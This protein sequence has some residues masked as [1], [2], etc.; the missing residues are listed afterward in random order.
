MARQNLFRD[1]LLFRLRSFNVDLPSLRSHPQDIKELAIYY[2]AKLCKQYGS[3]K[4]KFYPGFFNAL[5]AYYWPGN[6]RELIHAL[7]SSIVAA[8]E[9]PFL[10]PKHLP[11][12]IRVW[13]TRTSVGKE[14]M[15]D[16]ETTA[17]PQTSKAF[18]KL[19]DVRE[20]ALDKVEGKY[21]KDLLSFTKGDIKKAC[22]LSGLSRTRLY[23]LLKKH[24]I[25]PHV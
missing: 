14:I 7:E 21:L 15:A 20:I 22:E 2:T 4:K 16:K 11:T 18:L 19:K 12:Y 10:F 6:V 17:V 3:G 23:V 8:Q 9:E 13:L 24:K 25:S 5:E 1:D